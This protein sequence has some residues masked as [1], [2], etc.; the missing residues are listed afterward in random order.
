M[1]HAEKIDVNPDGSITSTVLSDTE[2]ADMLAAVF[3]QY[4]E[5]R[6]FGKSGNI[7]I[8][9]V[10]PMYMPE[11]FFADGVHALNADRDQ[12][13]WLVKKCPQFDLDSTGRDA[14]IRVK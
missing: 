10:Y 5:L 4:P 11:G 6:K 2:Q 7:R 12:L 8:G 14:R 9:R 1:R 3:R 13:D